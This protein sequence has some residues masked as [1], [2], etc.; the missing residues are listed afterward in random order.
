SSSSK[1]KPKPSAPKLLH[2]M[3]RSFGPEARRASM[4]T[5]GMPTSPNPPT[6]IEDPETMPC[7][8]SVA[9]LVLLS[10]MLHMLHPSLSL[11]QRFAI[12]TIMVCAATLEGELGLVPQVTS[13]SPLPEVSW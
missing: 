1:L 5:V 7:T 4:S 11:V 2:T 12:R 3:V 9:V 10:T 8:P 6:A 13:C